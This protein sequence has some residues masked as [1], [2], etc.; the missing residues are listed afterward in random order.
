MWAGGGGA[1]AL[2]NW[3]LVLFSD[4]TFAL[5]HLQILQSVMNRNEKEMY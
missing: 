4:C 2:T 1:G 3:L 5:W